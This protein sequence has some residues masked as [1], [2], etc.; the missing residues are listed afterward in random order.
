MGVVVLAHATE[1]GQV[2]GVVVVG[3]MRAGGVVVEELLHDG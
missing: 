2:F 1:D 3:W